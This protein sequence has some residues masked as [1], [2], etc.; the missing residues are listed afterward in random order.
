MSLSEGALQVACAVA[1]KTPAGG[2]MSSNL[3]D[4]VR[5]RLETEVAP[6]EPCRDRTDSERTWLTLSAE[7]ETEDSRGGREPG[8][9]MGKTVR[10]KAIR[11]TR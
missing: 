3:L 1:T 9:A 10:R 11:Y 7:D 6:K 5:T 4:A 2:S 8:E